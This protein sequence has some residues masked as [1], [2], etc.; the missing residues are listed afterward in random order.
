MIYTLDLSVFS[1]LT[2]AAVRTTLW[3]LAARPSELMA[4]SSSGGKKKWVMNRHV[5]FRKAAVRITSPHTKNKPQGHTREIALVPF[6]RAP[7][8][9]LKRYAKRKPHG[10]SNDPFFVTGNARPYTLPMFAA[11]FKKAKLA[12]GI[13]RRVSPACTRSAGATQVREVTNDHEVVRA[14]GGWKSNAVDVYDRALKPQRK[15]SLATQRKVI[16]KTVRRRKRD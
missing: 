3:G 15:A 4:K 13:T 11:A 12:A 2:F 16:G 1:D 6:R 7:G 8:S 9:L 10:S 5:E 14:L